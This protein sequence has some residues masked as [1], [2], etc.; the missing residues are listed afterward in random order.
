[1]LIPLVD[2]VTS[3]LRVVTRAMYERTEGL[4]RSLGADYPFRE[5]GF[6]L[7]YSPPQHAPELLIVGTNP[8]GGAGAFDLATES[9]PPMQHEYLTQSYPLAR[10][11]RTH[12]EKIGRVASL[13]DS[14]KINVLFFRTPSMSLWDEQVP[15]ELRERL[16]RFCLNEVHGLVRNL[17]PRRVLAETSYAFWRVCE[18]QAEEIRTTNGRLVARLGRFD[19]RPL[20]G[21]GHPSRSRLSSEERE[22]LRGMLRSFVDGEMDREQPAQQS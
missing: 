11:M 12:F 17:D 9:R 20:L 15:R 21:I 18:G 1:M 3:D 13:R 7:L 14:V 6:A 19:G 5:N 2:P 8:G 4:W 16:E 10:A 22:E